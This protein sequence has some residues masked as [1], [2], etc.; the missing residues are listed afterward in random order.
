MNTSEYE[1]IYLNDN[2][3]NKDEEI[4]FV[5][6]SIKRWNRN[7]HKSEFVHNIRMVWLIRFFFLSS[8]R[9]HFILYYILIRSCDIHNEPQW[10]TTHNLFGWNLNIFSTIVPFDGRKKKTIC[11][12]CCWWVERRRMKAKKSV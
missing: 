3:A 1:R 9:H 10:T 12:N 4:Q 5:F 7:K 8:F 11:M 6:N 2:I